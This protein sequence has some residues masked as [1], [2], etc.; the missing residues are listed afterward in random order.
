M[1]LARRWSNIVQRWRRRCCGWAWPGSRGGCWG[2]TL[3]L[4]F[5]LGPA[6]AGVIHHLVPFAITRGIV[7]LVEHPGR[8]TLAINRLMIGL[9]VYTLWYA[10]V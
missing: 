8:A 4:L 7:Q 2:D 9:P 3:R 6:L 5:G 10:F 1:E